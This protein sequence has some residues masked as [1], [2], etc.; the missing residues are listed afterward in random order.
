MIVFFFSWQ[1]WETDF[2]MDIADVQTE[3][4]LKSKLAS[5]QQGGLARLSMRSCDDHC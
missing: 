5:L 4:H 3:D 2:D 1:I